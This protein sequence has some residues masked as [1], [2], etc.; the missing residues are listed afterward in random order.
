M[1][2]LISYQIW[3]LWGGTAFVREY[4]YN[5][6]FYYFGESWAP[7]TILLTGI[8]VIMPLI[9]LNPE[10]NGREIRALVGSALLGIVAVLPLWYLGIF[11]VPE[12]LFTNEDIYYHLT[13]S[14]F[15]A[16]KNSLYF[17]SLIT[18]MVIEIAVWAWVAIWTFQ[19]FRKF[20][21]ENS[22]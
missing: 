8:L 16:L 15:D 22:K 9:T 6:W 13:Q 19:V 17:R 10:L 2:T 3:R 12:F 14:E 5:E 20:N 4:G 7:P 21:Q 18:M 1:I 11:G